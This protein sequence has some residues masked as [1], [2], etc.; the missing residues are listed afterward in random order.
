MASYVVTG[1]ARGIGLEFVTQLNANWSNSVFAVVRNKATANQLQNLPCKNITII[2]ADI[3][4]SNAL[5]SAANEVSKITGGKLDY[6]INN[7]AV[8]NPP[9]LGLTE[10]PTPDALEK[11]LI[12][13]FTVNTIGTIHCINA[14]LP[15][16]RNGSTKKVVAISSGAADPKATLRTGRSGAAAYAISKAALNMAVAKFVAQFKTEGFVFLALSPGMVNTAPPTSEMQAK[17]EGMTNTMAQV[18]PG[19]KGRMTPQESVKLQLE[20]IYKWAVED[21]G[22]FVSHHGNKEW[23]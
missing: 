18:A 17:F 10:F 7:A 21:T 4:N 5:A 9:R 15:L 14:F 22:A 13:H 12:Q 20:V 8:L 23:L 16:L 1:A 2:E 11:D 19:F 3:T 6:L